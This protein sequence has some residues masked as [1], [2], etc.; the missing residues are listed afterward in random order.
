MKRS[1][2]KTSPMSDF[3][4]MNRV[5]P[6]KVTICLHC[7]TPYRCKIPTS[8]CPMCDDNESFANGY[9]AGWFDHQERIHRDASIS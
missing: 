2:I 8:P 9:L 6:S 3:L 5:G 1:E 4:K 7:F